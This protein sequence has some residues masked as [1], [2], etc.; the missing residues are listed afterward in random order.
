M[1]LAALLASCVGSTSADSRA[2]PIAD[3]DSDSPSL[4][5]TDM[6]QRVPDHIV[7]H[8]RCFIGWDACEPRCMA[9]DPSYYIPGLAVCAGDDVPPTAHCNEGA[10][11]FDCTWSES[12]PATGAFVD[13][14][15]IIMP[16]GEVCIA[17]ADYDQWVIDN[18]Y[19]EDSADCQ[20]VTNYAVDCA[21]HVDG[22]CGWQ[23][24]TP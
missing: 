12:A 17:V 2:P 6:P 9:A 10:T 3:S 5:G 19:A 24:P 7:A 20:F 18:P 16:C 4:D 23:A 14:G 21:I 8:P 1:I 11:L 15:C 13:P 22:T